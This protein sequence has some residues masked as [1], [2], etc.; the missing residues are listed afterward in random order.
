MGF[1][2]KFFSLGSKKSRRKHQARHA[3]LVDASGRI[4]QPGE[5]LDGDATRLLRSASAHFSVVSEIDYSLL[6]P[7]RECVICHVLTVS[8]CRGSSSLN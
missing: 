4:V 5:Q 7:I 8:S 2:K 1:L 6:P 3:E